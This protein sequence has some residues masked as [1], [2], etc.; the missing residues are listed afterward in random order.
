MDKKN[1]KLLPLFV[2]FSVPYYAFPPVFFGYSFTP[3]LSTKNTKH[4]ESIHLLILLNIILDN[5]LILLKIF[6]QHL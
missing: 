5:S 6:I 2:L 4:S 3:R 1:S